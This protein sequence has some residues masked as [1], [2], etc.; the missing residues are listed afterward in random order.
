[1]MKQSAA[2]AAAMFALGLLPS[3][4][5]QDAEETARRVVVKADP[6]DQLASAYG[7]PPDLSHGRISTLTKSYVL[8]PFSVEVENTYTGSFFQDG[9]PAHLFT[10]EVELGFPARFTVG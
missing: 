10:Q 5:A 2:F 7:A 1:M 9:T 3:L 6:D 4:V 8:S